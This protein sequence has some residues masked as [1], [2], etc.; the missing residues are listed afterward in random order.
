[1]EAPGE[2]AKGAFIF[3]VSL[4]CDGLALSTATVADVTK[5]IW[6]GAALQRLPGR[7]VLQDPA[8]EISAKRKEVRRLKF[9]LTLTISFRGWRFTLTIS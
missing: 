7:V 1:M 8:G 5:K 6:E 9:R 3:R 2:G 4:Y